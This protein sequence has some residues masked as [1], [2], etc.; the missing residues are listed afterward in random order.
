MNVETYKG[1][2]KNGQIEL[3]IEVK[4]PEDS[5]VIVIVPNDKKPKFDLAE[6]VE[7]MPENY[8]PGEEDFGKPVG[9]E[10]W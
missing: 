6:M 3:S 2:V 8:E 9:K 1:K 5:D 7:N 4:L 10:V